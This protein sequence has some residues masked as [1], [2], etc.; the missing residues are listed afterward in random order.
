MQSYARAGSERTA[1]LVVASRP[2]R[3]RLLE[4]EV[5]LAEDVR[6]MGLASGAEIEGYSD[7]FQVVFPYRGMLVWHVGRDDVVGD[8]NQ[9]LFVSG[10]ESFRLTDPL[11][12]GYGELIVTPNLNVL[13]RL[14]EAEGADL[15][16]H[17]LFRRRSRRASP[18]LQS[19]R[20]RFLHWASDTSAGDDVGAED[21]LLALLRLALDD[22]TPRA[23]P[24]ASSGRL[25]R[26][27][28]EFLEAEFTNRIRL[29]HVGRAVGAS[30]EYL[31]DLFRRVEGISLHRYVIQLRLARA[32]VELPHTEDLSTLAFDVGFSSHSH[33]SSA[34][35]RAFGCTPSE[36]REATRSRQ[37][38]AVPLAADRKILTA[39]SGMSA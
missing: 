7:T 3:R 10:G 25:I 2:S 38:P 9:V 6:S 27:T 17:P 23:R 30:P 13:G 37:R 22:D 36:F 29:D 5:A 21:L 8:A 16:T 32:L 31:T 26:R 28:K 15:R 20:T 4:G 34:F 24:A 12:S 11:A 14:A 18:G 1:S 19:L 39:V 35:R 33:F